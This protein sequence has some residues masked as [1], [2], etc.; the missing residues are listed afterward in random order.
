[1]CLH[2]FRYAVGARSE[3]A[4]ACVHSGQR[5]GHNEVI[6]PT[7]C[8]LKKEQARVA[9]ADVRQREGPQQHKGQ[10]PGE[11]RAWAFASKQQKWLVDQ[12]KDICGNWSEAE[13]LAQEALIRF[14]RTFSPVESFPNERTCE[15]WLTHTV[16]NLFIDLCRRRK[17]HEVKAQGLALK[18]GTSASAEPPS[19]PVYDSITDEQ[20]EEALGTLS[21]KHRSTIEMHAEGKSYRDI[22]IALGIKSG[23]V[24]KR[25]HDARKMLLKSLRKYL[26]PGDN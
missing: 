6:N 10:T 15:A 26:P 18:D 22:A 7:R 24:G 25:L 16:T 9:G 20:F 11:Q 21:G 5:R 17:S 1:V 3:N 19:R 12:A 14:V 4:H 23:T 13:D 8:V 2:S